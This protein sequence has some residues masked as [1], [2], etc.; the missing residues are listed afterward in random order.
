[1]H[2]AHHNMKCY[3]DENK[4]YPDDRQRAGALTVNCDGRLFQNRHYFRKFFFHLLNLFSNYV[5]VIFRRTD[6]FYALT[7]KLQNFQYVF[8]YICRTFVK[9]LQQLLTIYIHHLCYNTRCRTKGKQDLY[10]NIRRCFVF[11]E[12]FI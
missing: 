11:N 3:Y 10:D 2:F 8:K 12:F 7:V 5:T 1:M 6:V 4:R 9:K